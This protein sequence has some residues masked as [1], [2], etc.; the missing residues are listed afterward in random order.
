MTLPSIDQW[1]AIQVRSRSE[2]MVE[3]LL[4]HK[5]YRTWSPHLPKSSRSRTKREEPLFPGYVFCQTGEGCHGLIVT[6]P[7]VLRFVGPGGHPYP[8]PAAEISAIELVLASGLPAGVAAME[9]GCAVEVVAGPLK[10]CCGTVLE[11]KDRG[12]LLVGISLLQR[13]LSVAVESE[14]LRPMP[15]MSKSAGARQAEHA[16]G[17]ARL[18]PAKRRLGTATAPLTAR[19]AAFG[20]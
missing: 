6:T 12:A 3:T 7:G 14:W 18:T 10:G 9:P 20:A 17:R 19:A 2:Q 5:G 16:C 11:A 15:Q 13:A 1:F 8:V 4:R